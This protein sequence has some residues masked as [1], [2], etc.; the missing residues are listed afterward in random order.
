MFWEGVADGPSKMINLEDGEK[1]KIFL[2]TIFVMFVFIQI[3]NADQ[4]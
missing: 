4:S 2:A 3:F 1:M